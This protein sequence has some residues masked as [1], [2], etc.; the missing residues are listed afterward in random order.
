MP[1]VY[2]LFLHLVH[3]FR[4][5]KSQPNT[6]S[7]VTVTIG[8]S[9]EK[10]AGRFKQRGLWSTGDMTEVTVTREVTVTDSQ[11][12]I[13]PQKDTGMVSGMWNR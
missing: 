13:R 10:R 9:H 3:L 4:R 12:E 5:E 6:D 11:E 1:S 7:R 2:P 8:G